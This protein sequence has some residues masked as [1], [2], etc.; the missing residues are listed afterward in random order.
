MCASNVCLGNTIPVTLSLH[1]SQRFLFL[2]VTRTLPIL[3]EDKI[4]SYT[5]TKTTEKKLF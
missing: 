5:K 1:T 3:S 2:S 4:S